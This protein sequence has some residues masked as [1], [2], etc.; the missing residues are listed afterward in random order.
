VDFHRRVSG[1]VRK[2]EE[3]NP[4]TRILLISPSRELLIKDIPV[5]DNDDVKKIKD[6]IGNTESE[7]RDLERIIINRGTIRIM[8][9]GEEIPVPSVDDMVKESYGNNKK[10]L[11]SMN[12]KPRTEEELSRAA[13]DL[14]DQRIK[15]D[16]EK[17]D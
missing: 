16:A 10:F 1:L 8:E 2:K 15:E 6:F 14:W 4:M 11:P 9:R 3:V 13:K 7:Y 12:K 5:F 17:A